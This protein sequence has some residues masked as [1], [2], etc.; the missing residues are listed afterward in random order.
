[1]RTKRDRIRNQ[2]I[3]MGLGVAPFKEMTESA[4]LRWFGHVMR[5]E[6][7]NTPP[8]PKNCPASYTGKETRRKAPADL[9]R[10]YT[11]DFEVKR[12]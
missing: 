5:M 7:E 6:D 9:G 11:E 1:L 3:R 12:N 4:Q 8:P 10:R 2:T